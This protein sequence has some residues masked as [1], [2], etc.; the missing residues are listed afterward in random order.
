VAGNGRFRAEVER[1]A[2]PNTRFVGRVDDAGLRDLFRRCRAVLMPGVEDFGIVP[3]EAQACGAPVIAID[4]GGARD[5]VMPGVTG[6]L[7]DTDPSGAGEV[8]VWARA[9]DT[10]DS[11]RYDSRAVRSHAETFSRVRFRKAMADVVA[12]TLSSS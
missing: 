1:L 6:E 3:V 10:F 8:A 12:R 2:G 5:S 7:V 4:A 9:L 11:T